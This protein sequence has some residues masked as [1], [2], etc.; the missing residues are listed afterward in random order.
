MDVT[1]IVDE[2]LEKAFNQNQPRWPKG[3]PGIGGQF[4]PKGLPDA[5]AGFAARVLSELDENNPRHRQFAKDFNQAAKKVDWRVSPNSNKNTVR[6]LLQEKVLSQLEDDAL[7]GGNGTD[8][9]SYAASA[10]GV[11]LSLSSNTASGPSN[12]KV[13]RQF[14]LTHTE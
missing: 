5:E 7:Q 8:T 11:S 13:N 9:A 2:R 14:P 3:T 10:A 6:R 1:G 12:M 4:R